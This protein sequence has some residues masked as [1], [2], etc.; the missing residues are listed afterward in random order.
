MA[1]LDDLMA[2]MPE[3]RRR[4]SIGAIELR[5]FL[6]REKR[7][8][9]WCGGA[10]KPPCRTWCRQQCVDEFMRRCDAGAAMRFVIRRDKGICQSCGRDTL[11]CER[12]W[13][14]TRECEPSRWSPNP[15]SD[16][17]I[18]LGF[19]RGQWREVDHVIPVVEGGG[20]LPPENLRLLCGVCHHEEC[21]DLAKRRSKKQAVKQKEQRGLFGDGE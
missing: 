6:G 5:K 15:K 10:V 12:V 14:A 20:L 4:R 8:C 21:R 19:S 9:T 7:T 13:R 2:R 11:K 18:L 3:L 17:V 16:Y 1:D